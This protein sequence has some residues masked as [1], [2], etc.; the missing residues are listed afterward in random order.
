M[1]GEAVSKTRRMITIIKPTEG[2]TITTSMSMSTESTNT[3]TDTTTTD[4]ITGSYTSGDRKKGERIMST[5]ESMIMS[6]TMSMN[7]DVMSIMS[8]VKGVDT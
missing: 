1:D 5:R 8:R 2:R 3:I 7:M 6:T 4:T